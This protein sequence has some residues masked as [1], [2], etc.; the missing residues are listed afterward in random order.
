MLQKQGQ[1]WMQGLQQKR[2]QEQELINMILKAKI[3]QQMNPL[4][5]ILNF[6]KVAEALQAMGID[7]RS[8]LG[9]QMP[10]G[11]GQFAFPQGTTPQR[12]STIPQQQFVSPQR[13]GIVPQDTITRQPS[14]EPSEWKPTAFGGL[15]PSKYE[16]AKGLPSESAG[17]F[18]MLNQALSDLNLAEKMLFPKR[19]EGQEKFARGLAFRAAVPGG[20]APFIGKVIPDT[21]GGRGTLIGSKIDNALEAKL[22]IETGAAATQEEFN[23]LK[24]RFG[25]TWMDTYAS[26]KDKIKRLKEFM[27]NAIVTI[28]PTGQFIYQTGNK[29]FDQELNFNENLD[30]QVNQL[31]DQLGAY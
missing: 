20:Q 25:I 14:V 16:R 26:A 19:A 27:R 9:G 21:L 1:D 29:K 4:Q 24:S 30:N 11:M 13:Q 18:T 3:E 31:L 22:R 7:P 2:S 23:R 15:Q 17:K 12:P 10:Q 5:N 6:G 8:V 28:D